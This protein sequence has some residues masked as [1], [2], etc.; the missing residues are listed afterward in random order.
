MQV[1]L[2]VFCIGCFVE[3]NSSHYFTFF[4]LLLSRW[5]KAKSWNLR[6]LV[7]EWG[8]GCRKKQQQNKSCITV[9][10]MHNSATSRAKA[11]TKL[12]F[13]LFSS[14]SQAGNLFCRC[15]KLQKYPALCCTFH[16]DV[17]NA[18]PLIPPTSSR[19]EMI[20]S[21]LVCI[22]TQS[23]G[24]LT[25]INHCPGNLGKEINVKIESGCRKEKLTGCWMSLVSQQRAEELRQAVGVPVAKLW[26][27]AR[28]TFISTQGQCHLL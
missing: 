24:E 25:W 16:Q 6:G 12:K 10:I 7:S 4:L 14:F 21:Y 28:R 13:R 20:Q 15:S 23:S 1:Q 17:S 19:L 27:A 5:R 2:A 26:L 22:N 9:T 3:N 11:K 18:P 8:A